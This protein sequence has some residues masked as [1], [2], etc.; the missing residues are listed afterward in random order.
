MKKLSYFPESIT[1]L[2]FFL[3]EKRPEPKKNL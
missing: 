1:K 2:P 3:I